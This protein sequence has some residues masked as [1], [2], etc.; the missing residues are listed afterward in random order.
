MVLSPQ[1][2]LAARGCKLRLLFPSRGWNGAITSGRRRESG[3]EPQKPR[4]LSSGLALVL[5]VSLHPRTFNGGSGRW[6]DGDLLYGDLLY[7]D[8]LCLLSAQAELRP[9]TGARYPGGGADPAGYS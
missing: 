9:L 8:L 7:G 6:V 3:E 2:A 4:R 1:P 5:I